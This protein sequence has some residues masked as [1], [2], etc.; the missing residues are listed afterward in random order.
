[1]NPQ[2]PNLLTELRQTLVLAFPIIAGHVGH[3]VMGL[4]D[5]LMIG[6]VG[7]TALAAAALSNSIF[8]VVFVIGIGILTSV[9]VLASH[10]H[11]ARD[12]RETGEVLR[13]G[14]LLAIASGLVLFATVLALFPAL[15]HL[16]QSEDV[17]T[18]TRPYLFWL[19]FSIPLALG[20]MAWK[21]FSEAQSSPW[22]AFWTGMAAVALNVFLNWVLIF[23][24]LGFPAL[25]LTGA[26][27]ATWIARGFALVALA[28]WV[29]RDGRFRASLPERWLA[30]MPLRPFVPMLAIGMPVALQIVMEVGAF[31]LGAFLMGWVGVEA[32]AAHQIAITCAATTFMIPLGMSLAV[33]IRIGQVIGAGQV[34]RVRRI[35][36]GAIGLAAA[37]ALTFAAGFLVFNDPLAALFTPDPAVRA[38]A[39]SLLVI[40]GC[41]Q[42]VDGIQAVALGSLRGLKDVR[43]PTAFVGVAYWLVAIPLGAA[44][45]F[46]GD[47]GARGIWIGLSAG[48]G[49]AAITLSV[50]FHLQAR[51]V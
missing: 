9:S 39:A 16:G 6:R 29:L 15:S 32:L 50:R 49:V 14:N 42:I 33:T 48:L 13:R 20:Q 12:F 41:F 40:A 37:I 30:R 28:W 44:L 7:V 21:N 24:N 47:L 5:T 23:G 27:I 2:R 26:G 43:V 3:M 38:L 10:A 31:N 19:A 4:T 34:A 35:G 22:P 11:G 25:G 18:A 51:H 46:A 1:M 36:F 45:A 8:H 17:V